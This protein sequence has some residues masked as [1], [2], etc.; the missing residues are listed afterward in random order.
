MKTLFI[1]LIATIALTHAVHASDW[2]WFPGDIGVSS[3]FASSSS[4]PNNPTTGTVSNRKVV[5]KPKA[6]SNRSVAG[7]K[8]KSTHHRIT[9]R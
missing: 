1:T 3:P 2:M 8:F 4:A 9:T 5:T 6:A 7:R